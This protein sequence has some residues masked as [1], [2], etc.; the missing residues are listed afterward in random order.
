[1]EGLAGVSAAR[2]ADGWTGSGNRKSRVRS[3]GVACLWWGAEGG[4]GEALGRQ[5]WARGGRI[6]VDTNGGGKISCD[7]SISD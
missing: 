4:G 3:L 2:E 7:E 5:V 6:A 1:M